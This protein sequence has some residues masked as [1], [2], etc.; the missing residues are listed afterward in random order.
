[1]LPLSQAIVLSFLNPIMASIAARVVMHEKLKITDIGGS[2][3]FSSSLT[4]YDFVCIQSKS[5]YD[6]SFTALWSRSCLQFLWRAFYFWPNT[7]CPRYRSE[8]TK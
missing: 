6:F 8:L 3:L 5:I 7:Y 4:I 2:E 1:M